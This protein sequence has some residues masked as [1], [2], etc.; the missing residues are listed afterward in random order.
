[1]YI[2]SMITFYDNCDNILSIPYIDWE[3]DPKFSQIIIDLFYWV[4]TSYNC[5]V[6]KGSHVN[7]FSIYRKSELLI[8]V[9]LCLHNVTKKNTQHVIEKR[10]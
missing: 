9:K 3:C 8:H 1:M 10:L 6:Y 7:Q 5:E 2:L 4:N